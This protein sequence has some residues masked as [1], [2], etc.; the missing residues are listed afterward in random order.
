MFFAGQFCFWLALFLCGAEWGENSANNAN[1][2]KLRGTKKLA[3]HIFTRHIFLQIWNC[4]EKRSLLPHHIFLLRL[5]H[6]EC[7]CPPSVRVCER[8]LQRANKKLNTRQYTIGGKGSPVGGAYE[9]KTSAFL[10]CSFVTNWKRELGKQKVRE[11]VIV[12]LFFCL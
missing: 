9:C 12:Y 2:T 3:F 5:V 6:A 7:V 10:F 8:K 1:D 4:N 11:I